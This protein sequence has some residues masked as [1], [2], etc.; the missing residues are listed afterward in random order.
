M[1]FENERICNR[2]RYEQGSK[3]CMKP[4]K[5]RGLIDFDD[6]KS[7]GAKLLIPPIYLFGTQKMD[8]YESKKR[9]QVEANFARCG[10]Q[11]LYEHPIP[12]CLTPSGEV[13]ALDMLDG[14]HRTR[15]SGRFA[16]QPIPSLVFTPSQLTKIFNDY[17][18]YNSAIDEIALLS[19]L[20]SASR[21]ALLSF[22][23]SLPDTKHPR[24]VPVRD[25]NELKTLFPSF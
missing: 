11:C 19:D 3:P 4:E 15:Y 9:R 25:I 8:E 20:E 5:Y 1:Q 6:Y 21:E 22:G 16:I 2:W 17:K 10:V 13:S 18:V 24:T 7:E 23:S 14:H 12:L